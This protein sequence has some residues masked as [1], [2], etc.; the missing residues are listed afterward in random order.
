MEIRYRKTVTESE[1][2]TFVETQ[3]NKADVIWYDFTKENIGDQL[4][5]IKD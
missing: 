5:Q 2:K 4:S 3:D 1:Y